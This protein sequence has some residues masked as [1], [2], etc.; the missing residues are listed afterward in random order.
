MVVMAFM[1]VVG[2]LMLVVPE[3]HF[4]YKQVIPVLGAGKYIAFLVMGIAMFFCMPIALTRKVFI[5]LL[6]TKYQTFLEKLV[7][8]FFCIFSIVI[9][10]GFM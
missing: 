4:I 9:S 2:W 3:F 5:L 6:P 7:M 8:G 1:G 10:R